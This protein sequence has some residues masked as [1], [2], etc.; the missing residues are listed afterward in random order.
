MYIIWNT[1]TNQPYYIEI[2][3]HRY[4]GMSDDENSAIKKCEKLGP[5]FI[6]VAIIDSRW[7]KDRMNDIKKRTEQLEKAL[8]QRDVINKQ[9]HL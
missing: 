4:V 7:L 8:I 9:A 3:D 2:G 1:I 6:P 5:Q